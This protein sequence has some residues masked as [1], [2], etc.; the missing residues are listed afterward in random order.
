MDASSDLR[1]CRSMSSLKKCPASEL[2]PSTGWKTGGRWRGSD[3]EPTKGEKGGGG[4]TPVESGVTAA[5]AAIDDG[6]RLRRV[7]AGMSESAVGTAA[8]LD[9][10]AGPGDDEDDDDGGGDGGDVSSC[11]A[12]VPDGRVLDSSSAKITFL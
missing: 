4:P 8:S 11:G 1:Q 6:L 2:R 9:K 10:A 12:P 5:A 3:E 7:D